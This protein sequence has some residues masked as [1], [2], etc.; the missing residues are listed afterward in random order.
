[1]SSFG[2]MQKRLSHA[3][4]EA[5]AQEYKIEEVITERMHD[6]FQ[7][8]ELKAA[9]EYIEEVEGREKDLQAENSNLLNKLKVKED[10]MKDLLEDFKV[11]EVDLQQALR[12]IN[13]YKGLAEDSQRRAQRYQRNLAVAVKDQVTS[14]EAIAKIERL[15]TQLKQHEATILKLQDENRKVAETFDQLRAQDAKAMEENEAK[16][17][18][19]L[20]HASA[21]ETESEQF[22]ETFTALIDTLE[23][24][25]SAAA[26]SL[27]DKTL[28]LHKTE[29][30]HNV[31]VSEVTPLNRF[32][33]RTFSMLRIYQVLFQTLS[34]PYAT[35]I[36]GL[37]QQLDAL[38]VGAAVDLELYEGVHGV[39]CGF[40][41]VAEEHVRL[42]LHGIWK[43]AN[44][45]L[46]SL[47][48][49]KADV[50][51]FLGRIQPE[52]NTWLAMKARFGRA[53]KGKGVSIS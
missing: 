16:V 46:S 39:L 6:H 47:Q 37:P 31:I 26:A 43:S 15:Q 38:M 32:F 50:A 49:I 11:K 36:A 10:E 3:L 53:G 21:V 27:N 4:A 34:D 40:G 2:D 17:A 14:D 22:S 41:G 12:S 52:P 9:R 35:G 30:L 19:I 42:Q 48:D 28:L 25:H 45:M 20:S 7:K 23:S 1:M 44:S 5:R 18:A 29:T 8:M 51:S 13:Y 33:D 24:E